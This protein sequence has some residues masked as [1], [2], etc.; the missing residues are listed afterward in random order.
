VLGAINAGRRRAAKLGATVSPALIDE[1]TKLIRSK[2][3]IR[4]YYCDC[5]VR[6]KDA[7]IDHVVPLMGKVKRGT[8]EIGNLCAAC[9][10]CNFSKSNKLI[11]EWEKEGQQ[12]LPI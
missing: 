9:P 7:H 11:H 6:G 1:F 2:R 3:F 4:C 12:M 5:R 8:H 10:K